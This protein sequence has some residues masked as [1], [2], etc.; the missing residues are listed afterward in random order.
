ML[1]QI[2]GRPP[3]MTTTTTTVTSTTLTSRQRFWRSQSFDLLRCH[4]WW[5]NFL[6]VTL[7]LD[8]LYMALGS[9]TWSLFVK[10]HLQGRQWNKHLLKQ[11]P[12][13][14]KAVARQLQVLLKPHFVCFYVFKLQAPTLWI[15][16]QLKLRP[17][18]PTSIFGK[19]KPTEEPSPGI[20]GVDDGMTKL[21]EAELHFFAPWGENMTS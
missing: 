1:E 12:F 8:F 2:W 3:S 15:K 17:R 19:F 21:F 7:G 11:P 14:P 4:H 9:K 20:S 5:T 10:L 16:S 13:I 6:Q 18:S